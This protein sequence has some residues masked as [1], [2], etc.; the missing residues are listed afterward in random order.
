MQDRADAVSAEKGRAWRLATTEFVGPRK[1]WRLNKQNR[2]A[3]KSIPASPA[4]FYRASPHSMTTGLPQRRLRISVPLTG[5]L[6]GRRR[7]G[8]VSADMKSTALNCP[9]RPV[10]I[11]KSATATLAFVPCI[12]DL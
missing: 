1:K 8:P 12:T 4:C 9:S 10:F 7:P 2:K 11:I 5:L 6:D 3:W